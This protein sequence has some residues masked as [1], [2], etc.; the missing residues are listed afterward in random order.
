VS[1]STHDDFL[2]REVEVIAA[3]LARII[4]LRGADATEEA[5]V[6]LEEAYSLLLGPQGD[7]LRRLDPATAAFMLASPEKVLA[8]ARLTV[9]E[10]EQEADETRRAS[11]RR[12]AL[13][14]GLEAEALRPGDPQT[15][16]FIGES[17]A[18]VDID[19]LTPQSQRTVEQALRRT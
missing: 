11:L 19:S 15:L 6:A 14:L 16:A 5:R 2:L 12:R 10:S 3:M 9:E 13:E 8:L 18:G 4:G 7:L 1:G 17:A